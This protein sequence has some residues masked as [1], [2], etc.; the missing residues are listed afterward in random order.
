VQHNKIGCST[1][2]AGQ[3]RSLCDVGSMSGLPES[4]TCIGTA[5]TCRSGHRSHSL[6][7]TLWH[8]PV[9]LFRLRSGEFD[10][11]GPLFGIGGYKGP[12]VG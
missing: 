8:I 5:R 2:A 6:N 12:K 4:R 9:G 3:T 10:G 11:L 1:S 7:G